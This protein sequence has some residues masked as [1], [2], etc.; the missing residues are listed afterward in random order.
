MVS[1]LQRV[2]HLL[3]VLFVLENRYFTNRQT[4]GNNQEHVGGGARVANEAKPLM[5]SHGEEEDDEN[6][7]YQMGMR[8]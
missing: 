6:E 1:K 8:K 7:Q 3:W 5:N 2:T 4:A